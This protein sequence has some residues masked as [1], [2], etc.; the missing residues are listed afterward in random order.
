MVAYTCCCLNVRIFADRVD[1]KSKSDTFKACPLGPSCEAVEL[2]DQGF[3]FSH[4]CLVQRIKDGDWTVYVCVPCRMR[5]HAVNL[6]ARLVAVSSAMKRGSEVIEQMKNNPDYSQ[7]FNLLLG[8]LDSRQKDD[9]DI[10]PQGYETLQ[11]QLGDLQ[12]VLSKYLKQEEEA[13][14]SRIRN[15]EEEQRNNFLKL[16]ERAQKE[17]TKLISVLFHNSEDPHAVSAQDRGSTRVHAPLSHS[18]SATDYNSGKSNFMGNGKKKMRM[19]DSSPDVF[20]MD[21]LDL[22]EGDESTA[23]AISARR[24][25]SRQ[26]SEDKNNPNVQQ[27]GR[28]HDL[29]TTDEAGMEHDEPSLMSTSV[30]I[31]MPMHARNMK[32]NPHLDDS[33]EET[34]EFDDIPDKMQALS[35][36]IQERDRYIFG[37]RPRQRVHTGDFTQVNWH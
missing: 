31:S 30:P 1:G 27:F 29:D 23:G 7:V 36:S 19:R 17:K 4:K 21:E 8:P 5:T 24:S 2:I 34:A 28:K 6:N 33:F 13:M 37:D 3:Q 15:Y 14:E 9:G 12:E 20:A 11:K 10:Q 22:D 35:E 32:V 18:K 16:K 25:E 26:I